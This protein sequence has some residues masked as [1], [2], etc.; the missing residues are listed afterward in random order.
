MSNEKLKY[1]IKKHTNKTTFP[2]WS[3]VVA[4]MSILHGEF[5]SRATGYVIT[6]SEPF[7][8]AFPDKL[9][10]YLLIGLG[11]VKLYGLIIG[12]KRLSKYSL[13]GLNAIWSGLF[14]VAFIY[15]FGIGHP[16]P[17]WYF[18]GLVVAINLRVA[19][20]GGY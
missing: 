10:G 20:K 7:S 4:S 3:L 18:Y 5:L 15:S 1:D 8:G 9:V 6:N 2:F 14:L 17:S 11:L 12:S 13:W 19:L 16:S